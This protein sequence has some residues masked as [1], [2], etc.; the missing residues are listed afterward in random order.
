MAIS[1]C[2]KCGYCI[3]NITSLYITEC[4]VC[5]TECMISSED[6]LSS[7]TSFSSISA[8]IIKTQES[9][10]QKKSIDFFQEK[11]Y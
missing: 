7:V 8:E 10:N 9:Y 3:Y 6:K 4:P 2:N 1:Y 11:F 5:H